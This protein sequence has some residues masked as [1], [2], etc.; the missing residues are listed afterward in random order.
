LNN[1]ITSYPYPNE[2]LHS[3]TTITNQHYIPTL[4]NNGTKQRYKTT[5]QNNISKQHY[6]T[7]VTKQL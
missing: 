6:K 4:Q 7:T 5:V 1:S 2:N 3:R